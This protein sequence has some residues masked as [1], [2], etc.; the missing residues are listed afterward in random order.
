MQ[1]IPAI[2]CF[3]DKIADLELRLDLYR[4]AINLALPASLAYM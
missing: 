2:R 1:L 3:V 4:K